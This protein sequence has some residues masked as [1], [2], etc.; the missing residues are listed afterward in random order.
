MALAGIAALAALTG[1]SDLAALAGIAILAGLAAL[2]ALASISGYCRTMHFPAH[3][4]LRHE[5]PAWEGPLPVYGM[6]LYFC[7]QKAHT[8]ADKVDQLLTKA[9][10]VVGGTP[11]THLH[12]GGSTPFQ[13]LEFYTHQLPSGFGK[14]PEMLALCQ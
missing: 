4:S 9:T 8:D 13:I 5:P 1:I 7:N 10:L 3:P 12:M 2:A 6:C 14:L 11:A